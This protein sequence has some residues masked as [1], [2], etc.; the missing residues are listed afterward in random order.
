VQIDPINFIFSPQ[1]S[2]KFWIIG[3]EI[4]PLL[5]YKTTGPHQEALK[6]LKNRAGRADGGDLRKFVHLRNGLTTPS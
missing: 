3:I 6:A 4:G 1:F 2:H 5:A